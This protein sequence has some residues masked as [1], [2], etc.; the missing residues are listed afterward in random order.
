MAK[1][2]HSEAAPAGEVSYSLGIAE[3]KLGG[4]N[5]SFSTSDYTVISDALVHPWL[6]VED[7]ST[8]AV[9]TVKAQTSGK[10]SDPIDTEVTE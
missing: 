5:P 6:S 8:P 7:D 9:Q 1:I 4:K 3:F 2:V 10:S